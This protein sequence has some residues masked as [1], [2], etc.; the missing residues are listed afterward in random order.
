MQKT[1]EVAQV[2]FLFPEKHVPVHTHQPVSISQD[3]KNLVDLTQG[4]PT[5]EIHPGL[6]WYGEKDCG[7][8]PG[9]LS[10]R[11]HNR[12]VLTDLI[13]FLLRCGQALQLHRTTRVPIDHFI[14]VNGG[15]CS[16]R[17]GG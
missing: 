8:L 15:V 10:E 12:I 11:F 9:D 1:E 5:Q 3:A 4:G 13:R 6:T 16:A 17:R 7:Q 14:G 2:R